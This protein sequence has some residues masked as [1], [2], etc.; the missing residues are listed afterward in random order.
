MPASVRYE[1]L[2]P[3]P[4]PPRGQILDCLA[5]SARPLHARELAE[6]LQVREAQVTRLLD[7]LDLLCVEGAV[8]R[9]SG[10][11]FTLK[12]RREGQS[13]RWAGIL[14]VNPRGFGFVASAGR[15]D[16]YVAA[17]GIGA[18]LHGD[19]VTVAIVNKSSRGVEGH[20]E[21]IQVRRNPRVAGTIR[22]RRNSL[23]LE[24]DDTRLRGPIVLQ[25][26]EVQAK[27]G[28]AAI[29]EIT[30]FPESAQENPE[31]IL[32]SVLGLPGD[33]NVEV[34]KI[35]A[36]EQI[37]EEHPPDAMKEAEAA[38][39]RLQRCNLQGRR[40]L[41][42]I[43]LPT[44]D[45]EE[46][47]DHDDAIWVERNEK[48]FR[49]YVAIA[50]VAEYVQP[51][52]ALDGEASS[53]GC[54]LYLPDRAV[55]MLPAALAADLCSLLP[56]QE[57]LCLC[58]IADLDMKGQL[59]S[60]EVVEGV[61][62]SAAMLTYG[63]VALALGFTTEGARSVQA[64]ALRPGLRVLDELAKKLRKGR[65][66]RGALDLNLPE[67]HVL[68]NE[69]TGA[70][71]NVVRRAKDPGVKRAYQMVEE[72]MLLANELV[73]QWLSSRRSLG[74][75]R[76]HATPDPEKLERLGQVAQQLGVRVDLEALQ[77]PLGL[78][79]WLGSI[80]EH[81][82]R[83]VLE[84][85]A[86]RSLK[87]AFYDIVNIGHF[88]L[89]SDAYLHFTSPIRRYPDL[90]VHRIVKGLLRGA[91]PNASPS[92]VETL[93]KI[94]THAS[95]RERASME[96][97][98]EVVDV[99]RVV[100]MRDKVGEEFDGTVTAAVG[101]GLF[102]SLD[103]PF[104]DVLVRLEGLGPD[105]YELTGDELGVVGVRSGDRVSVGERIRV[106]IEDVSIVRRQVTA[107]RVV[108][109]DLRGK[110][111]H[112]PRDAQGRELRPLKAKSR[113]GAK[114]HAGKPARKT[115]KR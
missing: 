91:Q 64:E 74:I 105:R 16:V 96:V 88:G 72:L 36:R 82:R 52:S 81:P 51:E 22:R 78:S 50:D 87:Q 8:I 68:L 12:S 98:R 79:R 27:D 17:E 67:A 99:Y 13:E 76:V 14:T 33:P 86:L 70:P 46:A 6:Q 21:S 28:M 84:S 7:L 39:A 111:A 115:R 106:V 47:R 60:F 80:S 73:A 43:P 24:P 97:E 57:R 55:P 29:A 65:L 85:T 101:S 15:P 19:T 41:R 109:S 56:E 66:R 110:R 71:T 44:I 107:R 32:V 100:L 34:A 9:R 61:M 112:L 35:L 95:A 94:A 40:D 83:A 69:S 37:V 53:R 10:Q 2:M 31:G 30:R 11:R 5:A 18:G 48:G 89:A 42:A 26:S 38:A 114:P 103:E 75:Y 20:I 108:L 93:R 23:W 1:W 58:V 4:L 54:T 45:P 104:V 90:V 113:V 63:G 77:D 62:R 25:P 92:A 59:I 102:V 49:A 3:K